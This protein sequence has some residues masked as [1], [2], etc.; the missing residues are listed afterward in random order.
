M[1]NAGPD[2]RRRF[3]SRSASNAV[4]A[5]LN[6][7][8]LI[9]PTENRA[10]EKD[11]GIL[12]PSFAPLDSAESISSVCRSRRW[13]WSRARRSRAAQTLDP[14]FEVAHACPPMAMS[15]GRKKPAPRVRSHGC[16]HAARAAKLTWPST[17]FTGS[18]TARRQTKSRRARP[19]G[20]K[21]PL[22]VR[23]ARCGPGSAR[24]RG[25]RV[26]SPRPVV[27]DED[28]VRPVFL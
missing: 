4:A 5:S 27:R 11:S 19:D 17:T 18:A 7:L 3:F 21:A 2:V 13:R 10:F 8:S 1:R 14:P 24:R 9:G 22:A 16:R 23:P 6:S 15:A 25:R 12:P 20:R 26:P 28:R